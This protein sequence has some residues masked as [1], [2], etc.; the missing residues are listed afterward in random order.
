MQWANVGLKGAID[1]ALN[2]KR[3][4]GRS[5]A[6]SSVTTRRS[7]M[8]VFIS[9][10]DD[11]RACAVCALDTGQLRKP[12]AASTDSGDASNGERSGGAIHHPR[13][14][15]AYSSDPEQVSLA[16]HCRPVGGVNGAGGGQQ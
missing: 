7:P 16:A 11:R 8:Q 6:V 4:S 3:M 1:D 13:D 5:G 12:V 14:F 2:L 10:D 15:R 9:P